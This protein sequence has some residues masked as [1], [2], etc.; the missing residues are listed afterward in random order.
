MPPLPPKTAS[1]R[2]TYHHNDLRKAAVEKAV[3][4]ISDRGGPNFSLRELATSLGVS[5]S[6]VYRHFADKDALLDSVTAL[7][8]EEMTRYQSMAQARAEATPLGQLTA[9]CAAYI[10]FAR[11]ERGYFA[12]MFHAYPISDATAAARDLHNAKALETLVTAIIEAQE[13]GDII[14]GDPERIAAF[15]VLS[16]HGLASFQAQ[17][18]VPQFIARQNP[19]PLSPDWLAQ[20]A[21]Q[22]LLVAPMSPDDIA[23]R[24][25][26]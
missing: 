19:G 26:S 7:G 10:E 14:P 13:N 21:L 8:F 23:R 5:H 15:L 6:A 11:K 1:T 9:L 20:L 24:F 18:H 12:L 17:G 16:P 2:D 22:P 3:Q 25:F 4:L